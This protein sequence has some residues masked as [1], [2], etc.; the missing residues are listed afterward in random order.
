M[1]ETLTVTLMG[2]GSSGGVPRVGN[3]WGSCDASEPRNR[4]RRCALLVEQNQQHADSNATTTLV[5]DT[6]ADFREQILAA[7][8]KSLDGVILTHSHADHIFGLDDLRQMALLLKR[9]IDVWMDESTRP[10]VMAAFGYCFHQ[11]EGSSYPLFCKEHLLTHHN[12]T[13]IDGPGGRIA[14]NTLVAEHGDIH[15]L[16]IK[17]HDTVYLPDVKR[18]T[19]KHSLALL[20]GVRILIVDAL[21]Y[22][23]HPSHM[24][25]DECLAFIESVG[26]ERAIL[27]NMHTD[28]DYRTLQASLPTGVEPGYDGLTVTIY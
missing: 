22:K 21:R 28:M 27:T 8:V 23:A 7:N 19:D 26:P 18:I 11:A 2:T 17:I 4:R 20:S 5:V 6:G 25:L 9:P 14:I 13:D 1:Q 16:G 24:N 12:V 3:Q 15:A 10:Q